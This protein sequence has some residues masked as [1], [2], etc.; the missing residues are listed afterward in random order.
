MTSIVFY[1][2]CTLGILGFG[3]SAAVRAQDSLAHPVVRCSEGT[4]PNCTRYDVSIVDLLAHPS[5]YHGKPIR[6]IGYIHLEFEYEGIYL[7]KEDYKQGLTRNGFWISF[8]PQIQPSSVRG[9]K[10]HYVLV[11]G[12][13]DARHHGHLGLWSGTIDQVTRCENWPP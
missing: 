1:S 10:D 11:E 13:F 5:L 12:I 8:D 4:V 6:A 9:C 7:H 3:A 2:L